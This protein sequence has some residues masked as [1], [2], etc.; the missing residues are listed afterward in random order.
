MAAIRAS[1]AATR[2][3]DKLADRQAIQDRGALRPAGADFPRPRGRRGRRGPVRASAGA[4]IRTCASGFA[5]TPRSPR[6]KVCCTMIGIS[7]SSTRS[8][9]SIPPPRPLSA[10][11]GW[12]RRRRAMRRCCGA[13]PPGATADLT[14]HERRILHAFGEKPAPR[15]FLDAIERIRFQLGQADRFH[16]GLI[17]AAA[18]ETHIARVLKQHG[19]PVEIAALP[20]SSRRSIRRPTRKSAPRDCGNSC[21]RPRSAS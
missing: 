1:I 2:S 13:S 14:A 4:R 8:C 19:V 18:W 21:R 6:T 20:T 15:D 11:G 12:R 9:G 3:A 17:R 5:C 16:E 10:S 7:I